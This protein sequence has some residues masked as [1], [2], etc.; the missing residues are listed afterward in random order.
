MHEIKC[1]ECGKVFKVDESGFESIVK[2]IRNHEFDEE[3]AKREQEFEKNKE[4]EIELE[5]EKLINK[6]ALAISEKDLHIAQ[7][8]EKLELLEKG[9][10]LEISNAVSESEKKFSQ[11]EGKIKELS[12]LIEKNEAQTKLAINEALASAE[13]EFSEKEKQ[14]ER[15]LKEKQDEIAY[16]KEYKLRQSTKMVGESLER[17]CEEKFEELRATAFRN[18]EF[19]KDNDARTGSK[20]DYIY[21]EL[22]ENGNELVS[23]MFEMKN[24]NEQTATKKKNEDFLKE[25]DKDRNEK[26]CE[27]AVLVSLLEADSELYNIGIVD[28]S[29]RYPKMYVIRPQYFIQIISLLRNAAQNAAKYKAELA[30]VRNQH[31]DITNFEDE[32]EEFKSAFSKNYESASKRF[33]EAIS[34]ID[35]TIE[36]LEKTKKALLSSENQLRLANNK[37]GDLSVKKLTKKNPTMKK[38]FDELKRSKSE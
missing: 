6:H 14:Y 25:L 12:A 13:E 19:G 37:A 9:K 21:R 15:E 28:K 30:L 20:G 36:H 38:A 23:I 1:P 2:Q 17:Y 5:R 26:N 10:A 8:T 18:A 32:I 11:A 24:Q 29:H 33:G 16:Y 34:E 3:I 27:Y 7:L 22:D 31:I 35:K 4:N